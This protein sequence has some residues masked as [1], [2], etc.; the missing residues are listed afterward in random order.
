M[1]QENLMD[2]ETW[3]SYDIYVFKNISAPSAAEITFLWN[4][5]QLF[6]K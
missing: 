3:I 6:K 2:T 4:F 5:K 1:F